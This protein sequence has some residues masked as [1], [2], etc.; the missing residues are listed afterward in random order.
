MADEQASDSVPDDQVARGAGRRLLL[1]GLGFAV[2]MGLL[3][4]CLSVAFSPENRSKLEMLREADRGQMG[5]LLGLA[6]LMLA[7]DASIFWLI[8]RPVRRIGFFSVQATN[9][10]ATFLGLLPFKIG[11]IFR[12]AAHNRRDGVPLPLVAA[13]FASFAGMLLAGMIPLLIASLVAKKVDATWFAIAAASLVGWCGFVIVLCRVFRGDGGIAK[14][15]AITSFAPPLTRLLDSKAWRQLH[16]AFDIQSYPSVVF[17]SVALRIAFIVA[18][19]GQ[20][21]VASRILQQPLSAEQSLMF[22]SVY[23]LVGAASPTGQLGTR[24]A[25]I[26]GLAATLN[27]GEPARLVTLPLVVTAASILAQI[28]TAIIGLIVLRP[29]AWFSTRHASFTSVKN[30]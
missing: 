28:P 14:L 15:K 9:A 4:W 5:T 21:Y 7:I 19:S 18:Q 10:V 27:L 1:Q 26:A 2:G 25:A 20:F 30:P 23:Y 24:E 29:N 22:A 6:L 13:W 16:A 17:G 12:I 8:L 3:A 11:M